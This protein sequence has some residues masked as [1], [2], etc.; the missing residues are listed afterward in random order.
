MDK[1][2]HNTKKRDYRRKNYI[3]LK[4]N[5]KL[6]YQRA[7]DRRPWPEDDA[8]E[9]C[10]LVPKKLPYHHWDDND[11]SKGLYL[12]PPHHTFAELVDNIPDV[13]AKYLKLRADLDDLFANPVVLCLVQEEWTAVWDEVDRLLSSRTG[14]EHNRYWHRRYRLGATVN[15]KL[16]HLKVENKRPHPGGSEQGA[17]E[18]CDC[19]KELGYHHWDDNELS[20]GLWVCRSCHDFAETID[21]IPDAEQ[22]YL[23][24]KRHIEE[25]G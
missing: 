22:K 11:F 2:E 18:L 9:F 1:E 21:H 12:C 13:S 7:E 20:K 8:C 15:G 17:C 10:G 24:L 3:M 25:A 4:R 14:R 19:F 6:I 16:V 23:E 5:G